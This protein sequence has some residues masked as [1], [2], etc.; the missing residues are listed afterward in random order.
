[1][2]PSHWHWTQRHQQSTGMEYPRRT[3]I[4]A[5][6]MIKGVIND[7][8][9][10]ATLLLVANRLEEDAR[11]AALLLEEQL[12]G[13]DEDRVAAFFIY[14]EV[15]SCATTIARFRA[16]VADFHSTWLPRL[17]E[18]SRVCAVTELIYAE[19]WVEQ[20]GDATDFYGDLM[21]WFCVAAGSAQ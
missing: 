17:P 5:H 12:Q 18:A 1:M 9:P 11:H 3:V 4:K 6:R 13:D 16:Q 10:G 8:S 14:N 15:C 19:A 2:S 7:L 21:E 20:T